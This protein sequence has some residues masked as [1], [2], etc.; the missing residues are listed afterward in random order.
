MYLGASSRS[1][2]LAMI[3]INGLKI[4][5]TENACKLRKHQVLDRGQQAPHLLNRSPRLI[6]AVCGSCTG[7]VHMSHDHVSTAQSEEGPSRQQAQ[8]KRARHLGPIHQTP[9]SAVN[10]ANAVHAEPDC[11]TAT[12][13]PQ[14]AAAAA[15]C[16]T[17]WPCTAVAF[18]ALCS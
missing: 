17:H 8:A 16:A 2:G 4:A 10:V 12:H 14:P 6:A 11:S 1:A 3:V 15:R 7:G 5:R 9:C 18:H 13:T